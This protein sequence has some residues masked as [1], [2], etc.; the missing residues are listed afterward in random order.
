MNIQNI[1]ALAAQLKSIGFENMAYPLL[2][3][4]C[5]IP[6]NFMITEKISKESGQ[7]V[8]NLYFEKE[9]KGNGYSLEYYDAILQK[10]LSF[11]DLSF[12]GI[13]ISSIEENMKTID[14]KDAFDFTT[15]K[16]FSPDDKSSYE[17]EQRVEQV[18]ADLS[19]L[20]MNDEGK[21]VSVLLKQ[22]YW[23]DIVYNDAMGNMTTIKAKSELSQ[24]FYCSEGQPG[25]SAD[26]AYRFLQNKWLEKELQLKRKQQDKMEESE[27]GENSQASAGSGLLKKRRVNGTAKFKRTKSSQD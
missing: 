24:R 25:I 12:E 2:K 15:K 5:L 27:P 19:R 10:E 17:K 16:P 1:S 8:F 22:K 7:V 13:N 4:I 3:R 9:K 14:W 20:E 6:A 11:T 26:E 23:S 18:M 21:Q